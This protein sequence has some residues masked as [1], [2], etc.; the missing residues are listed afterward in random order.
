[1]RPLVSCLRILG[2]L[3]LGSVALTLHAQNPA[4]P[5]A[6]APPAATGPVENFRQLSP[7]LYSGGEPVGDDA[8]EQLA[9]LGIRAIVS[10]DGIRP[11]I[12]MAKKHGMRYIH[13]PVGYDGVDPDER[14]SLTSVARDVQG[15]VLI[16]CHH[17][18]HRGPA[19]AAIACMAAGAMTNAQALEYLKGVGTGA[20][21]AGL[22]RDVRE[23]KPLPADAKLPELVEAAKVEPYTLAMSTVDRAWDGVKACQAAGWKAP[24]GHADM[25]PAQ[26]SVLVWE[27]LREARRALDGTDETMQ[28]WM[29]EAIE[30]AAAMRQAAE[31]NRPEEATAAFKRLDATCTKCHV[32]YRN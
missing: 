8:F 22:W 3:V 20:E 27:G 7:T 26:Q 10:V 17:G 28:K 16:H 12:E 29:D 6:A 25:S 14:A 30:H 19:S 18:K 11:N 31:G 32:E 9:K 4:A 15:P 21:F 1:M 2:L 13:I 5:P 23:F 24:P